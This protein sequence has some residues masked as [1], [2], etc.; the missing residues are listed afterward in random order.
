MIKFVYE[1]AP[2]KL[3]EV[4]R[5]QKNYGYNFV[6]ALLRKGDIKVDGVRVRED[7]EIKSGSEITLYIKENPPVIIYEEKDFAVFNKGLGIPS[8]GKNSFEEKVKTH[9]VENFILCHRLDTNTQGLLIFAKNP[10]WAEKFKTYQKQKIVSKY[11]LTVVNNGD[12]PF[13]REFEARA[14]LSKNAEE[15]RVKVTKEKSADS[16]EIITHVKPI[17]HNGPLSLLEISPI[18]GRTHQIRAHLAFLG[19]PVLG[20]SKYGPD[21]INRLY[22]KRKQLLVAYKLIINPPA[23]LK[24]ESQIIT[25]D[26]DLNSFFYNLNKNSEL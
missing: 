3:S 10:V 1:G 5:R 11:Y 14:Y 22:N 15:S 7:N 26:V 6:K 24:N 17:A 21:E 8:E 16:K 2:L 9:F 12:K 19:Q 20:D 25:L 13:G 4:L 23:T 18:T